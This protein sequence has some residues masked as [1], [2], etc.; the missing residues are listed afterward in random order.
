MEIENKRYAV[1]FKLSIDDFGTG[2][3]WLSYLRK[4]PIKVLKIDRAFINNCANNKDDAAICLAIISLAKS[5]SLDIIAEGVE[6]IEQL[7]FLKPHDCVY[8]G[9]Y[10]SQPLMSEDML[11]LLN[12]AS[13]QKRYDTNTVDAWSN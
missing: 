8:Q 1:W 9:Y 5:L 7:T 4:F 13:V 2:Y 12:D 10:F 11:L 6:T 3:S